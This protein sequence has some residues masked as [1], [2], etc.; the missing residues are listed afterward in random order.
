M[1]ANRNFNRVQALEKEV[2]HL[3]ANVHIGASGASTVTF[4]PGIASVVRQ[5]AGDYLVTL[6]DRYFSL[7]DF[8]G[9]VLSTTAQ[10]VTFQL[11]VIS[12][13]NAVVPT[14]EFFTLV[15]GV[16]TDVANGSALIL[17]VELKNTSVAI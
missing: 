16:P 6:Q 17:K 13:T 10:D 4:A 5:S 14:F 3:F 9:M 11:K 8:D 1:C 7:K 12:N 15:G 2:K